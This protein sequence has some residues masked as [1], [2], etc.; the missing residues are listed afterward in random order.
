LLGNHYK[1]GSN[2]LVFM[3]TAIRQEE[4]FHRKPGDPPDTLMLRPAQLKLKYA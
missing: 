3:M 2:D 4:F 1:A